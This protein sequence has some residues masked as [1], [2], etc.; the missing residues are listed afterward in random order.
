MFFAKVTNV[1]S[2]GLVLKCC[3]LT[4]TRA[5]LLPIIIQTKGNIIYILSET[6]IQVSKQ[7]EQYC[8]WKTV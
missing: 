3:L 8:A 5:P 4:Q 2:P 7:P 6:S 1:F